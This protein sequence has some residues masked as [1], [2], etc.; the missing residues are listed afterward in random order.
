DRPDPDNPKAGAWI[1]Y[2][3][4]RGHFRRTEFAVGID[5]HEARVADLNGDGRMDI[6]DKPYN[7]D[8]PRVDVWL[9]LPATGRARQGTLPREPAARVALRPFRDAAA[10]GDP[11][12]GTNP[13][14]GRGE[15]PRCGGA[16]GEKA[17][18]RRF[19]PSAASREGI[20]RYA[21]CAEC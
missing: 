9:Q 7:W 18:P 2:G 20:R 4:G 19:A 10:I 21:S 1:F 17:A 14:Q 13:F 3:D 6:L 8:T 15:R 5:F 16:R 12:P 11:R